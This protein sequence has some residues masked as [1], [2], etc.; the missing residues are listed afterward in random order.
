M[1]ALKDAIANPYKLKGKIL[2][3]N[4]KINSYECRISNSYKFNF[5]IGV[6]S[7]VGGIIRKQQLTDK[8]SYLSRTLIMFV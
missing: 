3:K 5:D 1:G 2:L 6:D 7:S 4:G 8:T